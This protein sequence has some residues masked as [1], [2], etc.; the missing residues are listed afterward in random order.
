MPFPEME[1]DITRAGGL[2]QLVF[3]GKVLLDNSSGPVNIKRERLKRF[4]PA[5]LQKEDPGMKKVK[6]VRKGLC[7]CKSSC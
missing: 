5:Q 4:N 2:F 3:T 7:K 1:I 6:K